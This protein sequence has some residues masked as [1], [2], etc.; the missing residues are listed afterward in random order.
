MNYLITGGA[1]FVGCNLARSLLE[2]GDSVTILDNFISGSQNNL[3]KIKKNVAIIEGDIRDRETLKKACNDHDIILH[4]AAMVSVQETI[5]KPLEAHE[6]NTTG[7][8]NVLLVARDAG[9]RRVVL[10]SSA[11]VYGDH[12]EPAKHEDLVP[13]PLSPY[14]AQKLAGEHYARALYKNFGLET[15]ILRYFNI[16]GPRQNP[17][18]QYAAVVPKFITTMLRGDRPTIFG[19][20]L[21]SRDFVPIEN[22]IQANILAATLDKKEIIATPLNI[23]SGVATNLLE[24][25]QALNGILGTSIQPIHTEAKIGDIRYSLA[26]IEKAK[27]LLG[28]EPKIEFREGLERTVAWYSKKI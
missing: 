25:V 15:V 21:Q 5:D 28:Y 23:A 7:T 24:L 2:R 10:A 16:L 1:G 22:I 9:V 6:N 3:E 11:A 4:H 18:S 14:A 13:E 17:K 8:L 20:G 26:N 19:D 27:K 12:S